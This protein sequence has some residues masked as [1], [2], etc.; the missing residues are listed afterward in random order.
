VRPAPTGAALR[1]DLDAAAAPGSVIEPI[2]AK[3]RPPPPAPVTAPAAAAVAAAPPHAGGFRPSAALSDG[4]SDALEAF[5]FLGSPPLRRGR[6]SPRPAAR[7][8]AAVT[9]AST[10]SNGSADAQPLP[11]HRRA[12]PSPRQRA[13]SRSADVFD[14]YTTQGSPEAAASRQPAQQHTA[15]A[16]AVAPLPIFA[17][18]TAIARKQGPVLRR[19]A[20]PSQPAPQLS[21]TDTTARQGPPSQPASAAAAPPTNKTPTAAARRRPAPAVSAPASE[22]RARPVQPAALAAAQRGVSPPPPAPAASARKPSLPPAA[23]GTGFRFSQPAVTPAPPQPK[24]AAR[25]RP[26]E[27]GGSRV[28][29]ALVGPDAAAGALPVSTSL[30]EAS[31][32]LAEPTPVAPPRTAPRSR[33]AAPTTTAGTARKLLA[34]LPTATAAAAAA[35]APPTARR[36]GLLTEAPAPALPPP[37][38]APRRGRPLALLDTTAAAGDDSAL[39]ATFSSPLAAA[40]GAAPAPPLPTEA[41]TVCVRF[42]PLLP[43]EVARAAARG[44]SPLRD[45]GAGVDG[46]GGNSGTVIPAGPGRRLLLSP[47]SVVDDSEVG[48]KAYHYDAVFGPAS[49]NAAVYA[50]VA[51]RVV[52]RALGGVNGCV[53]A[54]G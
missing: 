21:A 11:Q 22:A 51:A 4:D 52:A 9:A 10:A 48:R 25:E 50:T 26:G 32:L 17:S 29:L 45:G 6:V 20:S 44:R 5:G 40:A 13:R 16:A 39:D 23:R 35:A 28:L 30:G 46:G 53:L 33:S 2:F 3:R 27:G 47:T 24:S 12:S 8:P 43:R 1:F 18:P 14:R 7:Q 37:S 54:Y 19:A 31:A 36:L 34:G 42:R 49:S 15:A 41:I 38:T